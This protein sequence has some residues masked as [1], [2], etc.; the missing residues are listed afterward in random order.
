[1]LEALVAIRAAGA[2]VVITYSRARRRGSWSA[3]VRG[4]LWMDKA[5]AGR[6]ERTQRPALTDANPQRRR[7]RDQAVLDLALRGGDGSCQ[8]R[9]SRTQAIPQ[10]YLEHV[11][12][13]LKRAG[14]LGSKRGASVAT[15]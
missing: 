12:L 6:G 1:M 5:A 10:R 15:T 3:A 9:H 14:L 8:S 11:L 7:V 2:D 13:A 4:S